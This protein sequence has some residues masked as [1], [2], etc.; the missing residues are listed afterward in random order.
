MF[1]VM[2][3]LQDSDEPVARTWAGLEV[4]SASLLAELEQGGV[5]TSKDRAAAEPRRLLTEYRQLK[6]VQLAHAKELAMTPMS[7]ASLGLTVTAG[8]HH[9]VAAELAEL[10]LGRDQD[11]K[12]PGDG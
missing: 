9:N 11:T 7:R 4:I 10:R 5:V 3:W 12:D 1:E 6:G 8:R 2:P